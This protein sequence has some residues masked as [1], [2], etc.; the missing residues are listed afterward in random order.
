MPPN[1]AVHPRAA[2]RPRGRRYTLTQKPC[3]GFGR[4]GHPHPLAIP[5]CLRA[6]IFKRRTKSRADPREQPPKTRVADLCTSLC[7]LRHRSRPPNY[8]STRAQ[9]RSAL[10]AVVTSMV[11]VRARIPSPCALR[12]ADPRPYRS[13]RYIPAPSNFAAARK[14]RPRGEGDRSHSPGASTRATRPATEIP[15]DQACPCGQVLVLQLWPSSRKALFGGNANA[16]CAR[17]RCR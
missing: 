1:L 16:A 14:G 4:H 8:H 7:H 12:I 10:R 15:P 11:G 9:S 17:I 13:G 2:H 3:A 5:T 6:S